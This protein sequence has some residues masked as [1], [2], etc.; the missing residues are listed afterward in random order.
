[1]PSTRIITAA[2][3]IAAAVGLLGTGAALANASTESAA[4]SAGYSASSG[5]G[6]SDGAGGH[7]QTAVTG[8]ELGKVKA[9][10]KAKD[11]SVTV[12]EVRKDPDGS[13]DVFG[14]TSGERVMLEVGKDLKTVTTNAGRGGP[15][16]GGPGGGSDTAVTGSRAA[17]VTA[18]VKAKDAAVTVTEVRADPDGSYDVLGAKSGEPVFFEVS[19]D[20]TTITGRAGGSRGPGGSGDLG[21][22][23]GSSGASDSTGGAANGAGMS[24]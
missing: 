11:S 1:M 2:A 17:A 8:A 16:R 21:G 20:L 18:A 7:D 4:V 15:G 12:T 23:S 5:S 3:G 10:V 19:K 24:T 6:S 22:S 14:T 13:Y 9:A